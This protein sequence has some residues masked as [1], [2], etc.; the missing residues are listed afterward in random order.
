MHACHNSAVS[1]VISHASIPR[2]LL[3][4]RF[5]LFLSIM[6]YVAFQVGSPVRHFASRKAW[7]GNRF[8]CCYLKMLHGRFRHRTALHRSA[9][10]GLPMP[11]QHTLHAVRDTPH[12]STPIIPTSHHT[13]PSI[14]SHLPTY[15]PTYLTSPAQHASSSHDVQQIRIC[16]SLASVLLLC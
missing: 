7:L 12:H 1:H 14:T 6:S 5:V 4:Y 10:P 2:R 8:V 9:L 13:M 11:F 15:L 3:R 16:V